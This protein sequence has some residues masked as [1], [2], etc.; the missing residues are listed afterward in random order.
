MMQEEIKQ[1]VIARLE[2]LPH[3]RKISI[4][5]KGEYTPDQIIESVQKGDEIGK[6]FIEIELEFLR[7]LK[8]GIIQ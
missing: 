7:A 2:Q 8:H 3:N 6:K 5:S 1:L 4:G